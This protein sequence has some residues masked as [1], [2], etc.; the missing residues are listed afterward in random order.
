MRGVIRQ[1]RSCVIYRIWKILSPHVARP[2]I[3]FASGS[4]LHYGYKRYL[5]AGLEYRPEGTGDGRLP[6]SGLT[7]FE[8]DAGRRKEKNACLCTDQIV[9][10]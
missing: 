2:D 6:K 10:T 7:L 3:I 4:E 1:S 9:R 8:F 5:T